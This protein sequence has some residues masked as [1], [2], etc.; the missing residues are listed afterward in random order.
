MPLRKKTGTPIPKA[1]PVAT[2]ALVAAVAAAALPTHAV[3]Y[4]RQEQTE[5]CWAACTAMIAGFLRPT[6]PVVQQCALAN[7]L[8]GKT[9]CCN[10]P[11]PTACNRP[12][13]IESILPVYKTQKILGIG[14]LNPL[15][16][17]ELLF[18]LTNNGPVEVGYL[19]WGGGGH[20]AIVYG[21]TAS[22]RLA[23]HDPWFGSGFVTY[24]ALFAAYGRGRWALSFGQFKSQV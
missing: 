7:I 5:W 3:P 19:W 8:L 4:I 20:V 13:E 15:T 23:V 16:P 2:P 6:Q 17:N 1:A 11:T 18:E 21:V 10:T 12:C 14:E 22:D 9:N 24:Q